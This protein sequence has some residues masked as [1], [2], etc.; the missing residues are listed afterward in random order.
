MCSASGSRMPKSARAAS[1][2][3][4]HG[5]TRSSKRGKTDSCSGPKLT[6]DA[7]KDHDKRVGKKCLYC[8]K[9]LKVGNRVYKS[10]VA[11]YQCGVDGRKLD[12]MAAK[13]HPKV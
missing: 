13:K 7:L 10:L 1:C 12:Y 9:V 8:V 11:H 5:S 4:S 6:K 2:A 3:G